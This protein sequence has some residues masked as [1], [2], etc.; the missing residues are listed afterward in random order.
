MC[1]N[2]CAARVTVFYMEMDM[3]RKM[4]G[5][6]AMNQIGNIFFYLSPGEIYAGS[7]PARVKKKVTGE[8]V[9]KMKK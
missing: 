7:I 8:K 4:I 5:T 1:L 2:Y 3:K 6:F 9:W